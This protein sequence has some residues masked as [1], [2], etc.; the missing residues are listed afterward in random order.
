MEEIG[1]LL[2][3]QESAKAIIVGD[4]I[5]LRNNLSELKIKVSLI[6]AGYWRLMYDHMLKWVRVILYPFH[7][8]KI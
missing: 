6:H 4:L 5:S 7:F 3:S 2:Y 8:N 1:Q